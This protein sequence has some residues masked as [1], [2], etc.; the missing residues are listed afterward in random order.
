MGHQLA[1]LWASLWPNVVAPSMWTLLGLGAS[2]WRQERLH[3]K[4]RAHVTS[5]TGTTESEAK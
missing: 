3:R 4:T 5:A 1:Q 2:H